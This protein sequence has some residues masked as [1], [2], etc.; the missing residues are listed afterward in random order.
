[1]PPFLLF[2]RVCAYVQ[3]MCFNDSTIEPNYSEFVPTF[4]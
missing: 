2:L 1:M 3:L 4:R